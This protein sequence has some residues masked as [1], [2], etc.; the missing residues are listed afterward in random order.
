MQQ[1]QIGQHQ[2][3]CLSPPVNLGAGVG[4]QSSK[5]LGTLQTLNF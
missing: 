5:D 2:H 4:F 3:K 1:T